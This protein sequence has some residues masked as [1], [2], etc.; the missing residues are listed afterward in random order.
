M[1]QNPE[2]TIRLKTKILPLS[3]EYLKMSVES[4]LKLRERLNSLPTYFFKAFVFYFN[5]N[6]N[7]IQNF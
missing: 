4:E 7:K 5:E 6:F 2:I 3:M 1:V